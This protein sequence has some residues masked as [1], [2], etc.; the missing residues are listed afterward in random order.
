MTQ[1]PNAVELTVEQAWF[2]A[3]ALGV[4]PF[5]S[6]LAIT[7]PFRDRSERAGFDSAQ[8][9]ALTK[10]GVMT[11]DGRVEPVVAEWIQV[12]CLCDQWLELRYVGVTTGD[13]FADLM[14]GVIARKSDRSVVALRSSQLITFTAMAIDHPHALVPA[15][16]VG[17]SGRP[18][19]RFPEFVL[20]AR[21]GARADGQLRDGAKI[22]DVVEFL[23]VPA[24][25]RPVVE[26]VLS[27][28]RRYVEIVAGQ[29]RD[30]CRAATEVGVGIVDCRVGRIVITPRRPSDGEWVSTFGPG[31]PWA[32]ADALEQLTATL[33]DGPWF[34]DTPLRREFTEARQA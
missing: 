13:R 32:I 24:T 4:G 25:A 1:S 2:V 19:A 29:R 11:P 17:L 12:T 26:S 21:V 9:S 6:A 23:G 33:P 34:P 31:T 30:G 27:G 3:E 18:P 28:P 14:R 22:A 5:P 10:S 8:R 7:P 15:V 20:P 16:V